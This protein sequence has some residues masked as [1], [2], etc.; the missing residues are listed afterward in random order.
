MIWRQFLIRT[1]PQFSPTLTLWKIFKPGNARSYLST[2]GEGQMKCC[3]CQ[4]CGLTSPQS[5]SRGRKSSHASITI[6]FYLQYNAMPL[7]PPSLDTMVGGAFALYRKRKMVKPTQWLKM[8]QAITFVT[9]V[10]LSHILAWAN[11]HFQ[12]LFHSHTKDGHHL[13]WSGLCFKP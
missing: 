9:K 4:V 7:P 2:T 13:F 5:S 10:S 6:F 12:T 11:Q 8:L 1:D 3:R